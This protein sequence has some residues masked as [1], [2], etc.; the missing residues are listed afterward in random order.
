MLCHY[1]L[2]LAM[3]VT[4]KTLLTISLVLICIS[5]L[6]SDS[7]LTQAEGL[8]FILLLSILNFY[9]G[10][11]NFA[12]TLVAPG[13]EIGV[14]MFMSYVLVVF[15]LLDVY[16]LCISLSRITVKIAFARQHYDADI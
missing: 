4:I 6:F 8:L 13:L 5:K 2:K 11:L 16:D 3:Q 9:R 15:L 14:F 1:H 7:I 12:I 10:L